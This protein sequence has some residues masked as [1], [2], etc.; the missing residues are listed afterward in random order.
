MKKQINKLNGEYQYIKRA[1][2]KWLGHARDP[3]LTVEKE[4]P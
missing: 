4:Q 1:G 3:D 2:A